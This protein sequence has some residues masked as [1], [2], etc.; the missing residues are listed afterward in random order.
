LHEARAVPAK[1][2]FPDVKRSVRRSIGESIRI[3]SG[4]AYSSNISNTGA[5]SQYVAADLGCE[6]PSR[7]LPQNLR[8][9]FKT[10]TSPF[11]NCVT[12]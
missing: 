12:D 5:R 3:A 1:P 6:L 9:A 4:Y 10:A 7:L 8:A 2:N 11:V